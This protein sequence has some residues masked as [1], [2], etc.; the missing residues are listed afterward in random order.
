M[1]LKYREVQSRREVIAGVGAEERDEESMERRAGGRELFGRP[2][3]D[4]I[5]HQDAE[6]ETGDVDEESLED[7]LMPSQVSASHAT[8]AEVVSKRPFE[9]FTSIAQ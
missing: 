9:K 3:S 8:T 7:V 4:Q 1:A 5:S 2:G 6:I